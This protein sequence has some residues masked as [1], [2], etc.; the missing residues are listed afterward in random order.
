MG[1]SVFI[2]FYGN[3]EAD[4]LGTMVLNLSCDLQSPRK[5]FRQ[6]LMPGPIPHRFIFN[7]S[8]PGLGLRIF[9]SSSGD[10]KVQPRL[11]FTTHGTRKRKA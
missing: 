11:R 9:Q 7:Q 3:R 4:I 2:R 10:S 8:G 5:L 1:K 6:T